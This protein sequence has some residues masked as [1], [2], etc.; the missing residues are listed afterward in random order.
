MVTP[1]TQIQRARELIRT[2]KKQEAIQ[3]V[4]GL[5]ERDAKNPELWWLLAN[6]T[7]DYHQARRALDEMLSITPD[8][9][10]AQK[11]LSRL[12]TR[13]LLKDMGVKSTTPAK[14]KNHKGLWFAFGAGGAVVVVV[15]GVVIALL[16][17]SMPAGDNVTPTQVAFETEVPEAT[18]QI[19]NAATGDET[20]IAPESTDPV[21]VAQVQT[22]TTDNAALE[23]EV[24]TETQITAETTLTATPLNPESTAELTA[25]PTTEPLATLPPTNPESTAELPLPDSAGTLVAAIPTEATLAPT[26]TPNTAQG[27]VNPAPRLTVATEPVTDMRGQVLDGVTRRELIEPYGVHG[28]TFSGYR[29]ETIKIELVNITGNGNPSLELRNEAGEIIINAMDTVSIGSAPAII[30]LQLPADSIYTVVVRMAA[31]EEQLYSLVLTR[32]K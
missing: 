25:E 14:Q 3:M 12:E 6:A 9:P 4:A 32:Q 19:D 23:T 2:G 7:S 20:V 15:L 24:P 16:M 11:L 28:W 5:L 13:Q 26:I 17:Q 21:E 30:S 18:D 29:D 10:R 1:T 8:D 31:F 22:D 27:N